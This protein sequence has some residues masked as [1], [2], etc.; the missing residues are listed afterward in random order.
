[1]IGLFVY[2]NMGEMVGTLTDVGGFDIMEQEKRRGS[3]V[4]VWEKTYYG[5]NNQRHT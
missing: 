1:M 2:C 3:F 5:S 4:N